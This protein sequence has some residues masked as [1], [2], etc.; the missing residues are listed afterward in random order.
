MSSRFVY[1]L[2]CSERTWAYVSI[3]QPKKRANTTTRYWYADPSMVILKRERQ[4]VRHDN[5]L[6]W[7]SEACSCVGVTRSNNIELFLDPDYEYCVVPFAGVPSA[8]FGSFPFRL[9]TYSASSLKIQLRQEKDALRHRHVAVGELHKMLLGSERKL[10]YT[11]AARCMLACIHG[12][13][14]LVFVAING[15]S[16]Y[17]L[18]IRLQVKQCE[19]VIFSCGENGDTHGIPPRSQK[20]LLVVST[21][22][23]G[24]NKMTQLSFSYTSDVELRRCNIAGIVKSKQS[25]SLT[26]CVDITMSGDLATSDVH[27]NDVLN[28]GGDTVDTYSWIPQLGT[29]ID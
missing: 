19:A 24:S 8:N 18:S 2:T 25:T 17:F 22:G 14:C 20:I 1:F 6:G 7:K 13:G 11:I 5:V 15:S 27:E 21:D 10:V 12:R 3:V 26:Q 4:I 16:E 28:K 29:M 23:K 9:T